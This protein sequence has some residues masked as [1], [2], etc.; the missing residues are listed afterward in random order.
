MGKRKK[1][2][3]VSRE[4]TDALKAKRARSFT[5]EVTKTLKTKD[6][7]EKNAL[8]VGSPNLGFSFVS[9]ISEF[10]DFR[11]VASSP[12][13]SVLLSVE[14]GRILTHPGPCPSITVRIPQEADARR[15]IQCYLV[16]SCVD[17]YQ[18]RKP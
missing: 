1:K 4:Q 9:P 2:C 5:S 11:Q 8:N 15:P 13:A 18:G 7:I 10:Y 14:W 16:Y 6:T 3:F 12:W 17:I